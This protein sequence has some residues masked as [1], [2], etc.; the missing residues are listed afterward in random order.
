LFHHNRSI[1]GVPGRS[2]RRRQTPP[3]RASAGAAVRGS[4]SNLYLLPSRRG[5]PA[6][7]GPP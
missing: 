4:P 2:P 6:H 7:S 1:A 3:N 5:R